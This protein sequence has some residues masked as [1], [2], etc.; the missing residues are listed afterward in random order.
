MYTRDWNETC[1]IDRWKLEE[2]QYIRTTV[3]PCIFTELSPLNQLVDDDVDDDDN[4]GD[5]DDD[6]HYNYG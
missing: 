1:C 4:D 2:V 3:L 5:D 6:T